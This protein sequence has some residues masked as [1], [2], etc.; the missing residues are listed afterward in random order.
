MRAYVL[1][2]LVLGVFQLSMNRIDWRM[3]DAIDRIFN[4]DASGATGAVAWIFAL[5]LVAFVTRVA[6]RWF[7]FNA[8]RDVEYELRTLLL[9]RLHKLG[10][11]FYRTMSS[12]E[13]MSRSTGDLMQV[14][15]L[16]GFGVLNLV[17]VLFAFASAL[18]VMLRISPKLT[19]AS[20]A[21][22]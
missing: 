3:K 5:A 1:G 16:F 8:G 21:S 20:F 2:A 10:A 9:H 6:S 22:L 4:G 11:A 13:I 7:I 18:Q 12:G 17:N 19:L 14:R 15:L